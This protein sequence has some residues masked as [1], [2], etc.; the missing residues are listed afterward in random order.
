MGLSVYVLSPPS[1]VSLERPERPCNVLS[2]SDGRSTF[3]YGITL[4]NYSLD[5][6]YRLMSRSTLQDNIRNIKED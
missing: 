5:K 6:K 3:S 4:N 1:R 2:R